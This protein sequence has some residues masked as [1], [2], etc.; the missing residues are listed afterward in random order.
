[1]KIVKKTGPE[2]LLDSLVA[3]KN[4][5]FDE[6]FSSQYGQ[7]WEDLKKG[8]LKQ[9]SQVVRETFSPKNL[10]TKEVFELCKYSTED[11]QALNQRNTQGLKDSYVMD[12]A[13]IIAAMALETQPDNFV[14]DMCAAPGGKTLILL[15]RLVTG[16]LWAN[17]ISAARRI[18][19]KAVIQS[20][21][22]KD[23]RPLVHI[24]GKD[25]NRYGLNFKDTFDRILVDAPC[26]G[27]KH[28]LHSPKEFEKWSPKRSKRLAI[29]Q[30]S[31]LCSA[32]L[33]LKSSGLILYSTCSISKLEN[34]DVIEKLLLKKSEMVELDLP[35]FNH[36]FIEKTKFGYQILPDKSG[37]GPIFFSRLRKK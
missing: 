24:K 10:T 22:P 26:S 31:L 12:P 18:K 2:R 5:N 33:S 1:M 35:D 17:E 3:M 7:R 29:G 4:K 14:L 25:G 28:L 16:E 6:Y 15:E 20:H 21:T 27:E 9:E 30:Y 34:D 36:P 11:F 32:L 23:R 19:L 13:S 8:L 37:F